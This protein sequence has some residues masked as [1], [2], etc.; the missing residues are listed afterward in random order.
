MAVIFV[1]KIE[2]GETKNEGLCLK[3]AKEIGIP[4]VNNIIQKL[5][6]SDDDLESMEDSM[7]EMLSDNTGNEDEN[8]PHAPSLDIGKILSQMNFG[9]VG[10][11]NMIPKGNQDNQNNKNNGLGRNGKNYQDQKKE[12]RQIQR[13]FVPMK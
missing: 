9:P 7:G 8:S 6:I 3:C 5:G 13:K 2:N 10:N 4:Q 1:T 11:Q 12:K